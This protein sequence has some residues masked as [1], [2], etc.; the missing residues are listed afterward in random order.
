MYRLLQEL[1]DVHRSILSTE[2]S[3]GYALALDVFAGILGG[4]PG[5]L[6]LGVELA[7]IEGAVEGLSLGNPDWFLISSTL[8]WMGQG[9]HLHWK[10]H[11]SVSASHENVACGLSSFN[12]SKIFLFVMSHCWKFL[13]TTKP[14][15]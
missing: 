3:T 7:S 2:K 11:S 13:R 4:V 10:L 6:E 1:P 14:S 12:K 5:F 9:L 15:L 8:W